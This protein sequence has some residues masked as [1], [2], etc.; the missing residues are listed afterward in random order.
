M[1]SHYQRLRAH[2]ITR[3]DQLTQ[4]ALTSP[5]LNEQQ[6]FW[7]PGKRSVTISNWRAKTQNAPPE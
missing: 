2:Y 5:H 4:F 1:L 6:A 7:L 3:L